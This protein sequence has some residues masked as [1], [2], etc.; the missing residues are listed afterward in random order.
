MSVKSHS[1]LNP[2]R[3]TSSKLS[4]DRPGVHGREDRSDCASEVSTRSGMNISNM[5]AAAINFFL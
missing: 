3:L 4:H 1:L 5:T 2:R